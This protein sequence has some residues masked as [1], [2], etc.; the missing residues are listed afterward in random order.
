MKL[1]RTAD[2]KP[3]MR[4]AKPIYSK[5][6]VLLYSRNSILPASGLN[7]ISQFGLFGVYILEPAEPL[8]PMTDEEI[9]FEKFQTVAGFTLKEELDA[10][11]S[12]KPEKNILK[13]SDQI[14][15]NFGHLDTKVSYIQSLRSPDDYTYKHS[16]SVAM[17]SALIANKLGLPDNEKKYLITASLFHDIGKLYVP[18]DILYKTDK[19]T[20]E[21]LDLIHESSIKG[22]ELIKNNY[23]IPA[24][25]RRYIA[26]LHNEMN[27]RI[28][29]TVKIK[30]KLLLGT[31]IIMTADMF[32]TL[33]A[34]RIYK[35]PV[36]EFSAIK[37]LLDHDEEFDEKIVQAL[38][39]SI[40]ILPTGACVELTNGEKGVIIRENEY[41][42]LRP[43]VLGFNSNTVYDI[44]HKK[45]YQQIQIRD[46]MKTMDNRFV[47]KEQN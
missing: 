18:E 13:L 29:G 47:M 32:D 46:I 16:L 7:S 39:E 38:M 31:K 24:G 19:I 3:G 23:N 33:T 1:V 40:N 4:L 21:E 36:S 30:Q 9:E 25:I 5:T 43:T 10:A 34:L 37:F 45:T 26:Q 14:C 35:D 41:N 8:P 2:L 15:N 22:F 44:G 42:L 12:K 17:L 27:D 20:K 11:I 6:G 28:P